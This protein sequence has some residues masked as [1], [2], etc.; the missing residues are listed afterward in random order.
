MNFLI[1]ARDEVIFDSH[2]SLSTDCIFS[3][4]NIPQIAMTIFEC[5]AQALILHSLLV[6]IIGERKGRFATRS[7][8]KHYFGA[9][10]GG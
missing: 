1:F 3:S 8:W 7:L 10:S 9:V 2:I 4:A 5:E 6:P